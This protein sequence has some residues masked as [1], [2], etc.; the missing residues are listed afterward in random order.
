MSVGV[1][2]SDLPTVL[3]PELQSSQAPPSYISA[4]N[5]HAAPSTIS[6]FYS[7]ASTNTIAVGTSNNNIVSAFD[8]ST[9][10]INIQDDTKSTNHTPDLS[11][12][13]NQQS[14]STAVAGGHYYLPQDEEGAGL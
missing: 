6:D 12:K 2:T 9:I 10:T 11:L 13:A 1:D 7:S 3:P 4:T 5:L 14:D 8:S